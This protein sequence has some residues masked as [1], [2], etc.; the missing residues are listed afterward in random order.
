MYTDTKRR[1]GTDYQLKVFGLIALQAISLQDE[2]WELSTE[3]ENAG[4]F[5][6]VVLESGDGGIDIL[7]QCKHKKGKKKSKD[8]VLDWKTL[9]P[10]YYN[11]Y[12]MK[13]CNSFKRQLLMILCSNIG[14]SDGD[15]LEPMKITIIPGKYKSYQFK[16]SKIKEIQGILNA[17]DDHS[18]KFC[19]EFRFLHIDDLA[20][21]DGIKNKL[22]EA[23]KMFG[24]K[25]S[26]LHFREK[27]D[28]F[29]QG[30]LQKERRIKKSHV[31][32]FLYDS[33]SQD[34]LE[35]LDSFEI[36]FKELYAFGDNQITNIVSNYHFLN[37]LKIHRSLLR[38]HSPSKNDQL[39]KKDQLLFIDPSDGTE[40]LDKIIASF[41][42][43]V[44]CILVV[45][46]RNSDQFRIIQSRI[47]N[48]LNRQQYKK[49]IIVS[50]VPIQDDVNQDEIKFT[51]LTEACQTTLLSKKVNFQGKDLPIKELMINSL[52]NID[53]IIDQATIINLIND[54]NIT[55][56]RAI[57]DLGAIEHY[58]MERKF[59]LETEDKL[60]EFTEQDVCNFVGQPGKFVLIS[61]GAGKGKTTVLTKLGFLIKK[62]YPSSFL[63]TIDLNM[64]TSIFREF[65]TAKKKSINLEEILQS[66]DKN[67]FKNSLEQ[68][69]FSNTKNIILM[70]DAVD[71][72]SPD[73]TKLV[74]NFMLQTSERENISKIFVTTRPHLKKDLQSFLKT[75]S[76]QL[77]PYSKLE[78]TDFLMKYWKQN[79]T[80]DDD[81]KLTKCEIY[82]KTLISKLG[83]SIGYTSWNFIG[84]PLQTR[85][86][87]EIFQ[88]SDD[89][90]YQWVCCKDFLL[91]ENGTLELPDKINITELYDMF[92]EKKKDIFIEDKC[93]TQG[94]VKAKEI[95]SKIYEDYIN[96]H[97]KL[98]AGL[99]L[100]DH[101]YS[102]MNVSK[103]VNNSSKETIIGM[104]MLQEIGDELLFVHQTF[105]E[106]FL[107]KAMWVQLKEIA[108]R[109]KFVIFLLKDL[110][111]HPGFEMIRAFFE[112]ILTNEYSQIPMKVFEICGSTFDSITWD[113]YNKMNILVREGRKNILKLILE[114][115]RSGTDYQLK[116]FGLI[117]LEAISLQDEKWELSTEN[118]NAGKFDDVVL[119]SGDGGID[120][121]IQCKH[122]KG[123]KKSKDPVLDWKTLLPEYYNSY[124]MKICNSFKRKLLMILCSN[125]GPSD[126]DFLEP[127]KI[128]IIPGKYKSY[129]FKSSKIK[130]IQEIL[131]AFDDHSLKFCGE[132]RFLHIDDLAIE[133]GIKNKLE[134][135]QK[136]FGL[137]FSKLHFKEK[138]DE[139]FQGKLQK[140]RRIKKS[141]VIA[142]LYDSRSQDYL[143]KLDSFEIDFKEL[144]AFGDNQIT[145]IVSDYHFL[146]ILKIHRSLLKVH[147]PIKNDKLYKKDQLLFI[148]PSN[149]S[150]ILDK[151]IASFELPGYCVLVIS[152]RNSDQFRKIQSRINDILNKQQYK[153]VIILSKV[154]IQDDSIQDEIKFTDLT[155]ACRTTLLS[156]E[157]N[158]QGTY[159]PIKE[160]I[161]NSV[162]NIDSI[163][164][165]ETIIDLMYGETIQ[166]GTA[167]RDLGE[168]EH[169]YIE[170]KF[171]LEKMV[172]TEQDICNFIGQPGK[173]ILI[174]DGAGKGKT[175]VLT[176][177][178]YLIKKI[179]PSSFLIRID[180]NMF[181]SI[182]KEFQTASKKSINLE[183]ILQSKDKNYFKNSLEQNVF[184][185]TK[186]IIL[187]VDAVDEISPDYTSLVNN[188]MLQTS[189][190]KNI[191]KIFVTT[192]PH[193][194]KN[195]ESFL[196]TESYQL[197]PYSKLEQT[198]FLMKYWKQNLIIDDDEKLTKC[199]IYA[200][201]L[202]NKLGNSIGYTFWNFIG[203]PL[204]T[205][206]IAEIFQGSDDKKYQW[207]CCKDFLQ[208]DNETLELP[209]KINITELYDMF[210][211]K[212]K[213][214]F[215]EDKCDTQGNVK[216]K[217]IISKIYEDY[218]N[219]HQ[220]LAA[221]LLLND[222][223]Y[224]LM[225]VSK[226]VNNSSKETIIG[227]G[228]LQE[229]G[230]ELLFVHQTFAEYFLAKAMWVQLKEIA[231]R[232][233][234]VIFLLKDLFIHPGFEM[235]RAFFEGI[236]TNEYSQIPMKV[237]E[238]CGST[239]D[240]I[241]WD[242]YNKMNILVREGRKNIL[243]LT[244]EKRRSGTDYQLKVF[245][246]IALQAISLQDEKWELS[247]ENENAG[248]FDDVVFESGDGGIDILIQCKHKKGKKESK[249]PVLDW[250]TLLPKYYNSYKMKIYQATIINLI[251]DENITIGTAIRDLGAIENYYIERKFQTEIKVQDKKT[252]I[253]EKTKIIEHRKKEFTE[254]DVCNFVG[255]PGKFV[256]I[257][258]GAGKGKTTV[259]TKLGFLIKKIYPSSF[260]IRIDLNMFTSIFREF[261]T[262]SKKSINLE[263][264]LQSKDKNY[265]KNSLEQNIFSNTKN[266]ILMVDAVDE[267]SPDYTEL[268]ENF[269][270]QT[271]ERK[272]ISK[273]FVTTRPHLKKDLESFLKTESY[274]LLP[275]S[276]L[277]QTDFLMKYWKQ[278]LIIDDDEK[279]TKCEI[280][281]K[282]LISK[283]GNSIGYTSWNFIGIPLQTRM[284]AE[285]FQGSDDKKYQWVCC[286][287]FLLSENETLEL[288]DKINITELYDMFVEKKR[289]IFIGDKCDTQGNVILK[290]AVLK[291]YEDA[292]NEHQKLAARLLLNDHQ[293]SLMDV[294]RTVN[295]IYKETIIKMG[296]LQEIGHELL[297]VHQTF[298]EYFLAKAMWAQLK[299][300]AKRNKF[301]IFLLKDLFIDTKF[302]MIRA[303][304]EGI[305]TNEYSQIPMKAMT[306]GA[307]HSVSGLPGNVKILQI[308]R[309]QSSGLMKAWSLIM[310]SSIEKIHIIVHE[311]M[312]IY[313]LQ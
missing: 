137:K 78:Q 73:Y 88:G 220:K 86:I 264:I 165:Q 10:E 293:Y 305:L 170:R 57:R 42:L 95:I 159:L 14:P 164:D 99:L 163:I 33:R 141:H 267:I 205:R 291:Q 139:F 201:T 236:L 7:I 258:D 143:E 55:I 224:S 151:I 19:G 65:K 300:I 4:K 270:L 79:L 299:E 129:Q 214:I 296:M 80:I 295:N 138:I 13:I 26:K 87:A 239:F 174:S 235:I 200:K 82:A 288:P 108:K 61:D 89:K 234:F 60:Y 229:I 136:M 140:E 182:F 77:L 181:T 282:T 67:Y 277:E 81:E 126:G 56:G 38:V 306:K 50:K 207:V 273:I 127:I 193:L 199:E 313:T 307:G 213:D 209:D 263:E 36:D 124:K 12:K 244:I 212:K 97:Q 102:L 202:I 161:N 195:L 37:I 63:I 302:E 119:E 45:S 17:I 198:D 255:Q 275:Y 135:A 168:I 249:A 308:S 43:P 233:K 59:I 260:L 109:N 172:F 148:D 238:I 232:N 246:L 281:A 248:K 152:L 298:A 167:I 287:D 215:I 125:I 32:A 71:E 284:I 166:I 53:F 230:D 276:K 162:E 116:V 31:I 121:L 51:D 110:F 274:Q 34:Y 251:N 190:R 254:Q 303:F 262:A 285:I 247:T 149:G 49:V 39:Y 290:E 29:F 15:F 41:E 250:K 20:I 253:E 231:K 9:L 24:L 175:T 176:K 154:P 107:A 123:K 64:F 11:S 191:S 225:N 197:L 83:N 304:F 269:M 52:N 66:K 131:N 188:F 211:E 35:K 226:Y 216:A 84:I 153:K 91:S 142:F 268:V 93:D 204:Q 312:N 112:G 237:F 72:I 128:T 104:G 241:T 243:K 266:I 69:I 219:E 5:D 113:H 100:N 228:M 70:V 206:M 294:S 145:N 218:I 54:E 101:Q 160:L 259:L 1:S 221:G 184:S 8:P 134:E 94:N 286:K 58:Y 47:N 183:E 301:V 279:L 156:K 111:I 158:L 46:F 256:L 194:T 22:E 150:G 106:Y 146:N 28:E 280:Y 117:A 92:V 222:H 171:K 178:G 44:Y 289:D 261:E 3:N 242:H 30:K 208:C 173:F 133:D 6:D 68:N 177:L 203:I 27:I 278:N 2:K 21:E 311:K 187:M 75:E 310:V 179:Y 18:L 98:A 192:R 252:K 23:Q 180:L 132:F 90:K 157:V 257:S 155:E 196:K 144:Y 120:I 147:S 265:F 223:Q 283:L 210:V 25:F 118:E 292:K 189:E 186:N 240:S 62:I 122:K 130:E 105:A 309:E 185:N 169:Y 245:G 48:I 16:S 272:N 115:R 85:M 217:E 271:S 103:Y 114:K 74:N 96:E 297:F 40:I 227:M 76:Y